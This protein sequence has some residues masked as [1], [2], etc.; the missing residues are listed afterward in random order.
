MLT[1]KKID[2]YGEWFA[3]STTGSKTMFEP[4]QYDSGAGC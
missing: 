3:V 1:E 2:I 4:R